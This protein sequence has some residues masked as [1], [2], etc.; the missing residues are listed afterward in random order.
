MNSTRFPVF[1]LSHGGGPWPWVDGM[2]EMFAKTAREFTALPASLPAKPKAVL[3]ITGHWEAPTFSV[4]TSAHPPMDYDYSGFPEHTYHL[5]YPAPG[6]PALAQRVQELLSQAGIASNADP[7]RGFDHGTFV[8]LSLMYKEADVP[9]VLLSLKSDYDP[10]EHLRAGAAIAAL[11]DEGVLIIGSGLTYHN[12]S[13]FG[14]PSST[15]VAAAFESY[16][17]VAVTQPD[18]TVRNRMLV[19]WETA[20]SARL[21][22]PR[23]DH[24]LPLMVVAGAAG[25]DPG[26]TVLTDHVM[27]VAMASY[28]FAS[29]KP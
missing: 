15:P 16:L 11:R 26:E 23:E 25:D 27:H 7:H 5:K 14:R 2:K 29:R 18:A 28:R 24:L 20:P 4:S 22:H 12:M 9:V 10:A 21:A 1:F 17:Q 3:V 8:P 13:D 19:E 6:S